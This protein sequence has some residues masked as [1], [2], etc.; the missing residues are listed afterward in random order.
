MSSWVS[1]RYT[2]EVIDGELA[3]LAREKPD[4]GPARRR[5]I[6]ARADSLLDQRLAE[7]AESP[8]PT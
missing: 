1:R 4:A 5:E 7:A 2:I 3:A 6:L 8:A